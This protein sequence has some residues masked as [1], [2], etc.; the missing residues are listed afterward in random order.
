MNILI[1]NDDGI[2]APGI[3]A[4]A[5]WAKTHGTVTVVAPKTEQSGK[6]HGINIV[7]PF[8]CERV[9]LLPGVEAWAV[10]S[11]PADCVRFAVIHLRGQYDLIFSGINRGYNVGVDIL[12]SG[13]VGAIFEA[14]THGMTAIAVSTRSV[15]DPADI[16]GRMDDV[17]D[18]ITA[19]QLLGHHTLY[20][21]NI[22]PQA[23]GIRVTAQGG[24]YYAD[25]F[26]ETENGLYWQ[27]GYLQYTAPETPDLT[28]DTD[29]VMHGY[30]SLTPLTAN[31]TDRTVYESIAHHAG[32]W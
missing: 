11:T 21:V 12:Y 19:H 24:A 8:A 5:E 22:P 26:V 30:I 14:A 15:T 27:K 2:F 23:Q 6:S 31:R 10:D 32:D 25:S 7:T 3:R 28:L 9:D 17:W 20:N 18:F 4:L 16:V 1:T 29:A 13:T